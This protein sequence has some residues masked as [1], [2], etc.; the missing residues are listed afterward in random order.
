MPSL[1][2]TPT[3]DTDTM[4]STY[5]TRTV[6]SHM[7]LDISVYMSFCLGKI[8]FPEG[9]LQR[10]GASAQAIDFVKS[11]LVAD[12][13][14]RLSVNDALQ[15]PWLSTGDSKSSTSHV[16]RRIEQQIK[17]GPPIARQNS[18]GTTWIPLPAS[19]FPRPSPRRPQDSINPYRSTI[20]RVDET[21][22]K[23]P[24]KPPAL[25]APAKTLNFTPHTSW[26]QSNQQ[27][28]EPRPLRHVAPTT[29][30]AITVDRENR[31][32]GMF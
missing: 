20:V 3:L 15:S 5:G 8:G 10:T 19:E 14:Y 11:L 23:P 24:P 6:T 21:T 12:P 22:I 25:I 30:V 7:V 17:P 16:D 18:I 31:H 2:S 26:K 32:A 27:P 4:T 1:G 13:E 9:S 29:L 28:F